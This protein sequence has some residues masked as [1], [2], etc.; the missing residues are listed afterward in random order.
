MHVSLFLSNDISTYPHKL[1][2]LF[3]HPHN[4]CQHFI[5]FS[6]SYPRG[7]NGGQ[8]QSHKQIFNSQN[9]HCILQAGFPS[10][11]EVKCFKKMG[12][13]CFI[14]YFHTP[15][16][17]AL[18]IKLKYIWNIE[19]WYKDGYVYFQKVK[20]VHSKWRNPFITAH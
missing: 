1:D 9:L 19:H 11:Q 7:Q 14:L 12:F 15:D 6:L 10:Q 2:C 8:N 17:S 4:P 3:H 13:K 16:I 20:R 18:C 5:Y